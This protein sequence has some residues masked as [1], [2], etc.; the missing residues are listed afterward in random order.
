[1]GDEIAPGG[2]VPFTI[3]P[4]TPLAE[5]R[6]GHFMTTIA[7]A[8]VAEI[9]KGPAPAPTAGTRGVEPARRGYDDET[10]RGVQPAPR[11]PSTNGTHPPAPRRL[12][13]DAL[14]DWVIQRSEARRPPRSAAPR[15]RVRGLRH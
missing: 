10:T 6:G 5:G 4:S 1:G 12:E 13:K 2:Q 3:R 7:I 15:E 8:S 11:P 9:V 14:G